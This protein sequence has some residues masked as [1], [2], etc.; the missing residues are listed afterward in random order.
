M[1]GDAMAQE[2]KQTMFVEDELDAEDEL[3]GWG[4]VRVRRSTLPDAPTLA[5]SAAEAAPASAE[6][7][8]LMRRESIMT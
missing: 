8:A 3:D 6:H 1:G 2:I 5:A 7:A 4:P